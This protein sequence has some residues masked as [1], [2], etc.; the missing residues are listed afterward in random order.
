MLSICITQGQKNMPGLS[1][2]EKSMLILILTDP[3]G[4]ALG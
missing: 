1:Q 2:G 3:F 4:D